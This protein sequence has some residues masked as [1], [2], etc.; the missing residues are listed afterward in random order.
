MIVV[1][2]SVVVDAF[3][4]EVA[5]VARISGTEIHAPHL[6][7]LEVTSALRRMVATEVIVEQDAASILHAIQTADLH[8][9]DHTLLLDQIWA[10][11][12]AINPYEGAYVALA[13]TLGVPLV[14]ADQ[15]LAAAPGLTCAIELI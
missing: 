12:S 10:M 6:I 2:A 5:A 7:D 3:V 1:D 15:K 13:T 9:H 11:R 8:R 4:G 14:T